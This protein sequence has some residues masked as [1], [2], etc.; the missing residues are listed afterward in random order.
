MRATFISLIPPQQRL[1]PRR[2]R[3]NS[4]APCQ[5][6]F[7]GTKD[8]GYIRLDGDLAKRIGPTVLIAVQPSR[9]IDQVGIALALEGRKAGH[10]RE[11]QLARSTNSL[12]R[13]PTADLLYLF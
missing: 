9:Q 8:R 7:V 11:Q 3:N 12:W 10:D 2:P 4:E 5:L 13:L 1:P 6:S